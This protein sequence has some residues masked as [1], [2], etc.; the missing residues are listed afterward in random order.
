MKEIEI[1]IDVNG[2]ISLDLDGFKGK[3]CDDL[4]KKLTN[5]MRGK[6]KSVKKKNDYYSAEET[7]KLKVN[8]GM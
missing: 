4:I 5:A 8:R 3:G 1:T 2:E 7:Q 6:V